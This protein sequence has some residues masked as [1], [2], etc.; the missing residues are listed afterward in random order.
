MRNRTRYLLVTLALVALL[1]LAGCGSKAANNASGG[2]GSETP[3]ATETPSG[4]SS[5]TS[6]APGLYDQADGTV[7]AIG[8]L[9]WRDIE[10]GFW[11]IVSTTGAD[12]KEG[13]VVAV[14]PDVPKEDIAF[15][16]LAGKMVQATG[17]KIKGVSTRNA[18]PEIRVTS[19]REITD[20]PGAAE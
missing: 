12:P 18:G 10:G 5:G 13:S 3:A 7:L 8:E 4:A 11:A 9:Q 1:G 14:V 2:T 19:V 16:E 20:T 17:T 6:L 15:G